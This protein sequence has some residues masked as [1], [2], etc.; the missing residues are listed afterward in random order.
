[1]RM[2]PFYRRRTC[3]SNMSD[4][5]CQLHLWIPPVRLNFSYLFN[6]LCSIQ[7]FQLYGR[8]NGDAIYS[9]AVLPRRQAR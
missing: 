1:M 6:S 7:F 3:F 5:V 9:L 2:C 8:M 4:T